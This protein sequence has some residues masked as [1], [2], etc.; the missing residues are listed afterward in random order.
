MNR[1]RHIE[2]PVNSG[3]EGALGLLVYRI[4]GAA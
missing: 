4:G 3:I 2:P 1:I